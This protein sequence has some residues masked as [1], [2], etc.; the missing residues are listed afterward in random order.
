MVW[1]ISVA[2]NTSPC[3]GEDH[4]FDSRMLRHV[5]PSSIGEDSGFSYRKEGFDSPRDYQIIITCG[6]ISS[7]G[8]APDLHSGG[9]WFE[10]SI[11]HQPRSI[12]VAVNTSPCHGEDH[13]FDSRMLRHVVPSS[14]G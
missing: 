12:S 14:I 13:G 6:G 1:S 5:V 8:R 7:S 3:H 9:G 4:G 10:S 11:L 2:V